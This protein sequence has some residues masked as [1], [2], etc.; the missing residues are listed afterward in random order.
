MTPNNVDVSVVFFSSMF[1]VGARCGWYCRPGGV[2]ALNI[3]GGMPAIKQAAASLSPHFQHLHA[4][5][6][7]EASILF[8]RAA[9]GSDTDS[10]SVRTALWRLTAAATAIKP[11]AVLCDELLSEQLEQWAMND[12]FHDMLKSGF[13][14]GWF[15][16][17]DILKL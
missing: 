3:L 9:L 16:A 2:A 14:Y 17:Q 11:L 4:L 12:A 8:V 7:P 6:T 1:D 13:G 5:C 15:S 10:A